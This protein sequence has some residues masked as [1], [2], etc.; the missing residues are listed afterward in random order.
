MTTPRDRVLDLIFRLQQEAWSAIDDGWPGK[1]PG[2]RIAED[3]KLL[4][5]Y[6][7]DLGHF[8]DHIG[9]AVRHARVS[10]RRNHVYS[11][12]SIFM[13]TAAFIGSRARPSFSQRN[14][15]ATERG[16]AA[17][18]SSAAEAAGISRSWQKHVEELAL[19]VRKQKPKLSQER[20]ATAVLD[21]WGKPGIQPPV[22]RTVRDYISRLEKSGRLPRRAT[23]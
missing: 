14:Y 3:E 20:V 21:Q 13:H 19:K 7:D 8:S 10:D 4:R 16:R 22:H 17:G 23:A 1:M 12:L 15:F 2:K 9:I 6:I 18:R 11:L 5:S